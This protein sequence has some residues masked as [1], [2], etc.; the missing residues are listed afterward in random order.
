MSHVGPTGP[1]TGPGYRGPTRDPGRVHPRRKSTSGR[2]K[3]W[4]RRRTGVFKLPLFSFAPTR[5]NAEARALSPPFPQTLLTLHPALRW[6]GDSPPPTP[7]TPRTGVS[8]VRGERKR[9]GSLSVSVSPGQENPLGRRVGENRKNR[10]SVSV[11]LDCYLTLRDFVPYA[12]PGQTGFWIFF[13]LRIRPWK[14]FI[15]PSRII[16]V[17]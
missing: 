6:V 13:F 16:S 9:V 15:R 1:G 11:Y 8:V 4:S 5:H 10:L 17:A 7:P 3:N 12:R 2:T 14:L